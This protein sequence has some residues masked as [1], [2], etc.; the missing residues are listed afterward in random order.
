MGNL[1]DVVYPELKATQ[2]LSSTGNNFL[3][4]KLKLAFVLTD[5]QLPHLLSPTREDPKW[6]DKNDAAKLLILRTLDN[7]LLLEFSDYPTP[8]SIM[9]ALLHRFDNRLKAFRILLLRRYRDHRMA[10]DAHIYQHVFRMRAMAKELEYAGIKIPDEMQAV[11]LLNSLPDDWDDDVERLAIGLD[12]ASTE[13]LSFDCV[14]RRLRM[15][16]DVRSLKKLN[17]AKKLKN[18]FRGSCYNC[19]KR[20]HHQSDCPE[21]GSS[22]QKSSSSEIF[23]IPGASATLSEIIYPQLKTYLKINCKG[24]RFS[25]WKR[26]LF[27]VLEDNQVEYVLKDLK[28]SEPTDAA[29]EVDAQLYDKWH[30]DDFTCRHL[31]LGA[32]DDDVFLSFHDYPTAKALLYSLEA[33]FNSP[34]TAQKLVLLKKYMNNHMSDDTL[35]MDHILKMDLMAHKLKIAGVNVPNEMQSLVLLDSLPESWGDTLT[36]LN[37]NM[38]LD[39]E[40]GLSLDNVRKRVRDAGQMKELMAQ[41][42]DSLFDGNGNRNTKRVFRGK[43][44]SCGRPG[45]YQSDCPDQGKR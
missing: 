3:I 18:K 19:G 4:W 31:I 12:G 27:D 6:H 24:S 10:A 9:E 16:S 7:D 13:K 28:P 2:K 23:T 17:N 8:S 34:S 42:D 26:E 1:S 37:I 14:S 22:K 29:S 11:A 43:C 40:N 35:I 33:F 36:L 32:M 45:H 44:F 39:M 21:Q 41:A 5:H 15:V 38:T 20:G 30:A 25:M